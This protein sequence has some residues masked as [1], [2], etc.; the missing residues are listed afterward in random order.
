M[1][2]AHFALFFSCFLDVSFGELLAVTLPRWRCSGFQHSEWFETHT[3]E[4]WEGLAPHAGS[5]LTL[6][7]TIQHTEGHTLSKTRGGGSH[8]S[9]G[10]GE[11]RCQSSGYPVLPLS[12]PA[13]PAPPSCFLWTGSLLYF[14]FSPF[15]CSF[16]RTRAGFKMT[17]QDYNSIKAK[18][19]AV[20]VIIVK[21]IWDLGNFLRFLPQTHRGG[22]RCILFAINRWN[23]WCRWVCLLW[24]LCHLLGTYVWIMFNTA[25]A[26]SLQPHWAAFIFQKCLQF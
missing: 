10:I 6:L 12:P 14:S 5:N 20:N 3:E 17:T 1:R 13:P 24:T 8:C 18:N 19:R 9:A 2:A 7:L 15:H 4:E 16:D 21:V 11:S 22:L 26:C 23:R 25:V